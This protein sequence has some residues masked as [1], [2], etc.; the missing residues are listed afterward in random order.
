LEQQTDQELIV[1]ALA[2]DR[3]AFNPLVER[4]QRAVY[5]V[6]R[7]MLRDHDLADEV[8]QEAFVKAYFNLA[9]YDSSYRFYTWIVRI[10]MNLCYDTLKKHRRE[11]PLEL[12]AGKFSDD[13]PLEQAVQTDSCQRI[14]DEIDRLPREQ[15]EVLL[16][17]VDRELSYQEISAV[18]RI[19]IGSVMSRLFRARQ[20][21]S[22]SLKDIA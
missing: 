7:R 16:L 19:P 15:R 8:A 5:L 9:K 2:G 12:A 21:L 13:D 10:T 18:L 14:R 22:H 3:S 11:A 17:R 1:R 20:K 6:A 4:Y